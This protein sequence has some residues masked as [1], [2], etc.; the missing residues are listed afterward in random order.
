MPESHA[1]LAGPPES[2]AAGSLP[3]APVLAHVKLDLQRVSPTD[4][5]ATWQASSMRL[6]TLCASRGAALA[7]LAL[8][9]EAG[10]LTMLGAQQRGQ[11]IGWCCSDGAAVYAA[12]LVVLAATSQSDESSGTTTTAA[13]AKATSPPAN[14]S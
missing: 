3:A 11:D 10:S 12:V 7:T 13:P 14:S 1:D 5:T 2:Q 9:V 4:G 8:A 6:R